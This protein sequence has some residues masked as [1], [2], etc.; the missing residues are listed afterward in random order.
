[1]GLSIHFQRAYTFIIRGV[2][3]FLY[4]KPIHGHWLTDSHTHW[5]THLYNCLDTAWYRNPIKHKGWMKALDL[6]ISGNI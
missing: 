3:D 5:L 6:N 1:M 4:C 2:F